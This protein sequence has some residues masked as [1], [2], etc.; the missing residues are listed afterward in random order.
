MHFETCDFDFHRPDTTA[1]IAEAGV[2]HNGSVELARTLIDIARDAGAHIVKF[3]A[4]RAEKEIS[5]YAPKVQYQVTNTGPASTQL[6]LCKALELGADTLR[7]LK[8][9][10]A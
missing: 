4:F 1:V 3:Q 6:E 2:N 8:A 5:R 10:C 9:Y 7:L